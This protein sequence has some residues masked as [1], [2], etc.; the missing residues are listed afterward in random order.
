MKYLLV[1]CLIL[2]GCA[3]KFSQTNYDRMVDV[4]AITRNGDTVCATTDSMQANFIRIYNDTVWALE[5]AAGRGDTDL[6]KMLTEQLDEIDRFRDMLH[7]GN[8]SQFFCKQKVKNIY[9]TAILITK[10]EGN[11]LKL[12]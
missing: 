12:L 5:D 4:A 3:A 9:D 10:S 1:F 8:V 11:K 6:V 7:K 2:S